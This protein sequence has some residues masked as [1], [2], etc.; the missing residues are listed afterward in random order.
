MVV[1]MRKGWGGVC[2]Y[3]YGGWGRGNWC[4]CS[5]GGG[6]D[7]FKICEN[8]CLLECFSLEYYKY[9]SNLKGWSCQIRDY[10]V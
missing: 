3:M 8:S 6:V 9:F 2:M 10:P 7:F 1:G 5:R 4:C